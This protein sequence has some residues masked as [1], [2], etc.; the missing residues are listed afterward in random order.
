LEKI[1][2]KKTLIALAAVAVTSTAMAQVTLSGGFAYGYQSTKT[3]NVD[4]KGFGVDTAAFK[5]AVSEDLGGGMKLSAAMALGGVAR[6]NQTV[7]EDFTMVLSGGFGSLLV[8]QIEIG[9]GIRGLAQAGAPVNNMQGEILSGA[10]PGWDIVKYTSPTM[11]GAKLSASY[12]ENGTG[13]LASGSSSGQKTSVT[14][15]VDYAAGP[16]AAKI[17]M[18]NWSDSVSGDSRV[19][20]AA[21]Y[22]LGMVKIG[23]GIDDTKQ[24]DTTAQNTKLSMFG[25]SAPLSPSVT[26]GAVSVKEDKAGVTRNGSSVGVSYALSKTTSLSANTASWDMTGQTAKDKKTTV[27]LAHSF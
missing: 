1:S 11:G 8:G 15:G 6:T 17:D 20:V 2:M 18:T 10:T 22:D 3:N 12:V 9:S 26:V 24:V 14:V 27:L 5:M 23:Y 13:G 21:S 7:G 16:L 4:A 25:I 19:R